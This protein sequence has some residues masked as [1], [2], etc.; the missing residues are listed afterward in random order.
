[1]SQPL[2]IALDGP[3]GAGKST[4]AR[5]VARALGI[6]YLDT[7]AMYRAVGLKALRLGV[8]THD[9]AAVAAMMRDT[10]VDVRS[11]A[12]DQQVLLDGRDVSEWIRTNEVSQAASDVSRWPAVRTL[13]VDRQ[14]QI[15]AG[16]PVVMDGRDIGTHVL[17]HAQHKF[18]LTA[19]EQARAQRRWRELQARGVHSDLAAL[20]EQI[21]A[22]DEQDAAREHSPLRAAEDALPIDTTD[23]SF[24][25]VVALILEKI[26]V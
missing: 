18:Y 2:Q 26:S 17:P 10:L 7:G 5:A 15:A 3:S 20:R 1:M 13:L 6:T 25:Q 11:P 23:M 22:R 19:S 4:V 14:R 16:R 12:G 24:E 9:E 8:D 21:R